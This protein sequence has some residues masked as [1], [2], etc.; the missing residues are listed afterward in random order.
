MGIE[1]EE[2]LFELACCYYNC[3]E[4]QSA[5]QIFEKLYREGEYYKGID[6]YCTL[7]KDEYQSINC[8]L[9]QQ[10]QL[11]HQK[12]LEQQ[13]NKLNKSL[14]PN[15]SFSQ[16]IKEIKR[17]GEKLIE[18]RGERVEGWLILAIFKEINNQHEG[19]L[20][21][22]K[23]ALSLNKNHQNA[24]LLKGLLLSS[25]QK[26]DSSR[27]FLERAHQLNTRNIQAIK[28]LVNFYI[29]SNQFQKA[30]VLAKKSYEELSYNPS[31]SSLFGLVLSFFPKFKNE[32]IKILKTTLQNHPN[33]LEAHLALSRHHLVSS[34]FDASIEVLENLSKANVPP[35][36][37]LYFQLAEIFFA[38]AT[39]Q[40]ES[41]NI[42]A[43]NRI[44]LLN[45]AIENYKIALILKPHSPLVQN[46]IQKCQKLLEN[47]NNNNNSTI[48]S[49]RDNQEDED[50]E[51]ENLANEDDD[52][53]FSLNN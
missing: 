48:D 12:S 28:A 5:L 24:N 7:L 40:S 52:N 18:R 31:I 26:Y 11:S 51:S 49:S 44:S 25:L 21:F 27:K 41:N 20:L 47:S 33:N 29:E 19:A 35:H 8:S 22:Y 6:V 32:G 37:S 13:L 9:Y 30:S 45:T 34:Q 46:G 14:S 2:I 43:Q 17:V 50:E 3:N 38:K 36:H 4:L 10:F 16:K 53:S 39:L 15:Q 42:D 1:N 23:K